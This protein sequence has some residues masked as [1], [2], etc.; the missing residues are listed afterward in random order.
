LEA[1]GINLGF[2]IAFTIN[3]LIVVVVLRKWVYIPILDALEKRRV[4]I[5]RGLEDARVASEARENAEKEAASIISDAQAKAGQ[6]VREANERAEAVAREVRA[7]AEAEAEREREAAITEIQQERE[8]ILSDLRGQ[9]AALAMAVAQKLIG[10]LLDERRQHTLIDEFFSGVRAGE[11]VVLE[12]TTNLKGA[13]ADVTSALPL[14]DEEK[15]IVRRDLLSKMGDQATVTF[16]VD[17]AILGGLVVRVGDKVWDASVA[18]Q[19][20]DLRQTMF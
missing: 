10:E 12:D 20:E 3:F 9:V 8:R 11:V 4:T 16:R 18:G 14:S 7:E 5:A 17:P 19:M 2:L 1:L 6:I 13:S 15:E